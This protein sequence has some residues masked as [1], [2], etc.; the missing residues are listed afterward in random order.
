MTQPAPSA[1]APVPSALRYRSR[2]C[3]RLGRD[4]QNS[5]V[6]GTIRYPP[7]KSGIGTSVP[8]GQRSDSSANRSSSSARDASTRDC[9]LVHAPICDPRGREWKYGS[10][11]AMESGRT[12]P[13]TV[14]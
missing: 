14:T 4:C 11:S 13:S 3:R 6:S 1:S 8:S 2:S 5:I 7:Q 9:R 12:L 10:L